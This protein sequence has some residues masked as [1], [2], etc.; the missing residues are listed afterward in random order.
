MK[1]EDSTLAELQKELATVLKSKEALEKQFS[2]LSE[3]YKILL[4]A[5]M[6]EPVATA[7]LVLAIRHVTNERHNPRKST[8]N[9]V[10]GIVVNM[11]KGTSNLMH[12]LEMAKGEASVWRDQVKTNQEELATVWRMNDGLKKEIEQLHVQLAACGV[13]AMQNTE[14]SKAERLE[15][16]SYGWSASYDDVCCAVNREITLREKLEKLTV[17][18]P[19][20][21]RAGHE[22][23]TAW[24][25]AETAYSS[26][27][28]IYKAMLAE[29]TA[30]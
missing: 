2:E 4:K 6:D 11:K 20:M 26:H 21:I 1:N 22:A 24:F 14:D 8:P 23:E 29:A 30:T 15:R 18:T 9:D 19:E 5:A 16:Y 17:V 27:E 12:D 3:K 25:G 7:Q 13:A 10:D 28:V